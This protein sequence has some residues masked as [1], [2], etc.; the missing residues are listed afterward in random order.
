MLLIC[1]AHSSS[2]RRKAISISPLYNEGLS[3]RLSASI[4]RVRFLGMIV[5]EALSRKVD[6]EGR[7]LTFKVPETE[8]VSAESWRSFIDIDDEL[9][10]L[11]ELQAGIVEETKKEEIKD[12]LPMMSAEEFLVD[13]NEDLDKDLRIYAVP[14]S[15][16]EDSDEDPT[17]VSREKTPIPLYVSISSDANSDTFEI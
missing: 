3:N 10:P 2:S 15:D 12:E 16:A 5:G 13:E 4:D 14:D 9:A 17:L 8:E 6:P 7:R 1:F 11:K